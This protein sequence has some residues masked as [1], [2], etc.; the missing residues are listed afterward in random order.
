VNNELREYDIEVDVY[1]PCLPRIF[2]GQSCR[3]KTRIQYQHPWFFQSPSFGGKGGGSY[4]AIILA[5]AH[6]MF[7]KNDLKVHKEKGC[8][9]YDVKGILEPT[10]V[11]GR[12]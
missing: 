11:D 2:G 6:K 10:V 4:G 12:L 3:S 8:I 5:V 1:D 9:I 7:V